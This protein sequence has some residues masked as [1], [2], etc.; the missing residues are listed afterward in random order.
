MARSKRFSATASQLQ[1]SRSG[2][3]ALLVALPC[4]AQGAGE[5][6]R[7]EPAGDSRAALA[8]RAH[9]F[10]IPG[11]SLSNGLMLFAL[12]SGV[13]VSVESPLLQGRSHRAVSGQ[14]SVE[15]ALTKLLKDSGLAWQY[16]SENAISVF[17]REAA[18]VLQLDS[19]RVAGQTV[20]YQ[21]ERTLDRTLIKA[22]PAGN[23]D[24][25]SLLRTNPSVQFD[26]A[27]LGGKAPGEIG[28]ANI[29]I[30]GARYWQNLFVLDGMS[31]NND[32]DP[33]STLNTYDQVEGRSQGLAVDTDLLQDIKVYD[34]NVPASYGGFNGGVVE[35]NTRTPTRDFHGKVS[36]QMTRSEW[37]RYHIDQ[38]DPKVADFEA[39]YGNSNQPEF[40]KLITRATLEG[41]LT[42]NV[43][44]LA[45]FSR[46]DST[47]PTRTFPLS[48]TSAQATEEHEQNRRIDNYFLKSVWQINQ[49]WAL[50]V[51]LTHAPETARTYGPSALDSGR[52]TTAGG[53]SAIARLVWNASLA[54][55][56]QNL[57]WSRLENSRSSDSDYL[58]AWRPSTTKNWSNS[59]AATEG[60]FG[61]IEQQQQSLG[62]KLKA[63]W[64][65]FHALGLEHSL[66]TGLELA[67]SS[68]YYDR[69]TPYT[70]YGI[71][72]MTSTAT[73]VGNDPLCS[74]GKTSNGWAGQY[75]KTKTI[76]QGKVEFETRSWALF[77]QDEMRWG[78]LKIRPGV[79]LDSDDYMDQ[80]TLAPRLAADLDVFG[81]NQTHLTAGANRYY[82]RNLSAYRLR[83]GVASLQR[84]YSRASQ[85]A[86]WVYTSRVANGAK[87]NQLDVPYDDELTLGLSQIQ[88][89]TE[90]ALKYVKRLGRDQISRAW[91][92]QIG[93]PSSDTSTLAANYFTY[94]NGGKSTSET[95]TLT[96]T[97][98]RDFAL[99]G[100][101]TSGQVA[102]DW[103]DTKSS[104]LSDYTTSIG[105]TYVD[106]PMIQ[107]DGQFIRYSDR[108]ADNYNRP[109]TARLTTL[110]EIPAFNLNWTNFLRYRDGYRRMAATGAIVDYN[111]QD[112]R[113]W[114]E[115]AYAGALSWDTRL[116]WELPTAHEQ[117]VFVNLDVTNLLDKAIVS[118]TD[119]DDY[120]NYEVGRQF[121][122]EVG[123]R[124]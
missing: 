58:I 15:Q 56:E 8:Q 92:S 65:A 10:N 54:T 29:S 23:G 48:Q 61:D 100:T 112:A 39:G 52:D 84:N 50:D 123:Y 3:L 59:I 124:F 42:D 34:S 19:T 33:G 36:V 111:G 32:I 97:P 46:K 90:F 115:K 18:D 47:I 37:T 41:Y 109:W 70:S 66:Q 53:D 45:N 122:V 114:K 79:R 11:G 120:A 28:P 81:D 64:N 78:Q 30:N 40:D 57:S 73:C 95:W 89:N 121:M 4:L 83:D 118:N 13:Q 82:G 76:T 113:V 67:S 103:T 44:L 94:Y 20:D 77:V 6:A 72:G 108:P 74:V 63:D 98:L 49:D 22:M 31:M 71:A 93:Q 25:T 99:W 27:Q 75:A 62:Y 35:A 68:T 17:R 116:A 104:G 7:N 1:L 16:S 38:N 9:A 119:A 85:T 2:I 12:Q 21:S 110:T 69:S 80:T 24:I 86:D 14:L 87:F 26:D 5:T 101:R 91:G 51:S 105:L 43:G 88:W 55:V 102:L 96:V 117:A 60:G 106:D 107:Y